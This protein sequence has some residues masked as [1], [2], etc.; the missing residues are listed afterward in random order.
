MVC[1]LR[2]V[3]VALYRNCHLWELRCMGVA[4]WE[5]CG[6]R[7]LHCGGVSVCGGHGGC[8]SLIHCVFGVF[9]LFRVLLVL[10]KKEK[11]FSKFTAAK[12]FALAHFARYME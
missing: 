1:M 9:C 3:A 6:V 5:S 10:R 7:K 11:N 12:S 4:V 8:Q 2:C